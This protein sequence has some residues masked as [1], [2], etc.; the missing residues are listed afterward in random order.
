MSLKQDFVTLKYTHDPGI[1]GARVRFVLTQNNMLDFVLFKNVDIYA[2]VIALS[3]L[4][5]NN[6]VSVFVKF[7]DDNAAPDYKLTD[8]GSLG[9]L[10]GDTTA[11][12]LSP[13]LSDRNTPKP[14]RIEILIDGGG[15]P[16]DVD[17]VFKGVKCPS[18]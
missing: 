11:L 15:D 12:V 2:W 7:E 9:D 4:E 10:I 1:G 17:I 6:T 16:G 14:R 13:F 3:G 5:T 18:R 8:F